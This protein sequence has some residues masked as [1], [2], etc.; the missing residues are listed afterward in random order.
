MS[1]ISAQDRPRVGAPSRDTPE[2]LAPGDTRRAIQPVRRESRLTLGGLVY[3]AVTVFLA[4]GAI[5]SQN[6]LLFWLFGVAIATLIV[7]GLFSGNA[8]MKL[9][10]EAQSINDAYA[11]EPI[12]L[13]YT[14]RNRSRFFP[15]LAA[16][17]T[18]APADPGVWERIEPAAV[19]HLGPGRSATT[20][21]LLTPS[22]RGRHALRT[23]GLTTRFPFGLLQK[24]LVFEQPRTVL[25]L[26]CPLSVKPDLV[27][28]RHGIGEE[29]RQRTAGSG[30]SS[31]YWGLRE[32]RPGDSQRSIAWKPSARRSALVVI[33][34]AQPISTRLW[35]W[36]AGTRG[37]DDVVSQER[38]IA[39]GAAL[40]GRGCERGLPVGVWMP[41]LGLRTASATG[42]AHAGRCL[43]ALAVLDM[44]REPGPDAPPPA[45]GRDEVLAIT[46]D[47]HPLG[48][49]VGVRRLSVHEPGQWLT[50]PDLLPRVLRGRP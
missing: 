9:R 31:E 20:H 29:V 41:T 26:P 8:L 28:I 3:I 45:S 11:G 2:A 43:R 50:D 40:V 21:A 22:R 35:I 14:I 38:A 5:N 19:M 17:V 13:G 42:R 36:I 25:V 32:Y 49:G 34:H 48:M 30:A 24:S 46:R 6:N 7:S 27:R 39:L 16:M 10:L 18:E 12:R 47:D 15:L 37:E 44:A 4:I 33:E 23:I 1:V